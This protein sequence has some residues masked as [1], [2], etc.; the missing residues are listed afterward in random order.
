WARDDRNVPIDIDSTPAIAETAPPSSTTSGPTPAAAS[1]ATTANVDTRPSCAPNTTSRM[2]AN[3]S[4]RPGSVS[5]SD[6]WARPSMRRMR[7]AVAPPGRATTPDA[8]GAVAAVLADPD[9]PGP[10]AAGTAS[11]DA[12]PDADVAGVPSKVASA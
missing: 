4:I 9:A 3:R 8:R 7:A 2:D 11:E 5:S 1:P 6:M 10:V 12:A